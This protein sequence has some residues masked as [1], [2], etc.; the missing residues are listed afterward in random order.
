[1]QRRTLFIIIGAIVALLIIVGVSAFLLIPSLTSANTATPTPKAA[2]PATTPVAKT[3]PLTQALKDNSTTIK[4]QI[5]QGL[6]L[7][8]EQLTTELRSGKTLSDI[9]TAQGVS[10]TQLQTLISSAIQ[11]G[12]QSSIA[13]GDITQ[14]Q[15]DK[16]IKRLQS[17]PTLL[18]RLLGAGAKAGSNKKSTPTPTPAQ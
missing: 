3:N 18:D 17:N 2:T 7:T 14:T 1:M 6:K 9:A 10:S 4:S 5:A 15:V 12:L 11:S 13:N 16:Y 8:P